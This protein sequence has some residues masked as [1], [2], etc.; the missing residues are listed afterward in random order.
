MA[1]GHTIHETKEDAL[2]ETIRMLNVY[3]DFINEYLCIPTIK[4]E[5]TQ[6]KSLQVLKIL[7]LLKV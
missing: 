4:G 2:E 1:R 5:K 7:I 6:K 3:N